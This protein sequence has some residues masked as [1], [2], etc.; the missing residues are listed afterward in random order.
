MLGQLRL[1]RVSWTFIALALIV[2]LALG[3]RLHGLN[4]DSGYG[5]HP[6]EPFRAPV[7]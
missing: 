1:R 2:L 5:F 6:D 4:W 3:L 7:M